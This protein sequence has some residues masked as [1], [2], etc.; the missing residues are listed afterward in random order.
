MIEVVEFK[1]ITDERGTLVPLEQGIDFHFDVKRVYFILGMPT[2]VRRGWH[3]HK[4]LKQVLVCLCGSCK[5]LLDDG[6]RQEVVSLS[7]PHQGLLIQPGI[8][9]EMYDF[10]EGTVLL[11]LAS[12]YYDEADYIREYDEFIA[13]AKRSGYHGNE[14]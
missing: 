5:V 13:Y 8:W 6:V 2:N 11:T 12:D 9:R 4:T 1:R 14:S 10:A 3:A 7:Q